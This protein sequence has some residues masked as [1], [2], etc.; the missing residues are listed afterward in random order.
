MANNKRVATKHIRD[1][2][3]S[4]YKKKDACEVCGT[5]NELELHH[6]HTVSILLKDYA[7]K[8]NIDIS[9]DE[10]VLAMRQEFYDS[11]WFELVEDTVTLCNRH[12]V[13]LH[14]IY[15]RE[16]DLS[17][18]AKQRNWVQRKSNKGETLGTESS[19]RFL[20]FLDFRSVKGFTRFI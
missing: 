1:G 6:Y 3:K 8:N 5:C 15:G 11:H 16:P 9:T 4:N 12:H 14:R 2:I 18:A 19:S 10:A 13:E 20:K 7:R 17:T